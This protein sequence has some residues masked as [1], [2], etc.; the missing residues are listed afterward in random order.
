M[1]NT[2]VNSQLTNTTISGF[3]G[4]QHTYSKKVQENSIGKQGD[5][6][7]LIFFFF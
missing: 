2:P 1:F 3:L 5:P 7:A 4:Y 6:A